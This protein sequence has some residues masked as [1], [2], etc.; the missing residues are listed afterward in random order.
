MSAQPDSPADLQ[1]AWTSHEVLR[2]LYGHFV[3]AGWAGLVEVQATPP[4]DGTAYGDP[5]GKPRR[6]DLLL[7]RKPRKP[8]LGDLELL[9]VEVKVSRADF[10]SDVRNPHKQAAWRN[11]AHRHAFA[12]PAGLIAPGEVPDGSGLIEVRREA[13]VE[14][15]YKRVKWAVRAPYGELPPAWPSWLT[16]TIINRASWSEARVKGLLGRQA[17]DDSDP[18]AMRAEIERLSVAVRKAETAESKAIDAR[19]A[20]KRAYAAGHGLPCSVCDRPVQPGRI[21]DGRFVVWK[22]QD[23]TDHA[24]CEARRIRDAADAARHRWEEHTS[25][26]DQAF[27][28]AR[29]HERYPG[30]PWRHLL[31]GPD[32]VRPAEPD[33]A[34]RGAVRC[35]QC[36]DSP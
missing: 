13:L 28:G 16:W 18:D 15:D 12:A 35:W 26:D 30:E 17:G 1:A 22:H 31:H 27:Y 3:Q 6:I 8:E 21:S 11:L 23:K 25:E 2:S 19:E 20:W 10:L 36:P 29:G 9:A 24:S 4:Q 32:P 14:H 33:D 5:A 7:I 34:H